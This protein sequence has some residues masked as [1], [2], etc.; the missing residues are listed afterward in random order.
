MVPVS[1]DVVFGINTTDSVDWNDYQIV[2]ENRIFNINQIGENVRIGIKLLSPSRDLSEASAFDEYGP[3]NS[4]LYVNT[5]DFLFLNDSGSAQDYHFKITLYEDINLE[6]EVYSAY[7]FDNQE[8]FNANG[9]K[10]DIEGVAIP[11]N[12]EAIV[13]FTVPGSANIKCNT[14]YFV[15]IESIYDF[16][17][18]GEGSFGIFSDDASFIASC[19]S[20]FVD[21]IDYNFTNNEG[22]VGLFD[23]RIRFYNN[24]ER[25]SIYKTVFSQNDRTGWFVD[26]AAIPELGISMNPSETVNIVY[27][28]DLE[29][30]ETGVNYY[31]SID[32]WENNKA[33]YVFSSNSYTF[34]SREA[35]SLIYCGGYADVPVVKNFGIMLELED[36]QFVTLNL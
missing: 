25:T 20:S 15:K 26:D 34:Q 13:L 5:I 19:S 10:I 21:V 27:R 29:E 32:A 1:A 7:S 23:F 17:A 33:K 6:N 11:Y 31:L 8:G 9:E 30:F 4:D 28:P 22:V 18:E 35:T 3:Y 16:D 12:S 14:Y 2:D 36:N 24:P